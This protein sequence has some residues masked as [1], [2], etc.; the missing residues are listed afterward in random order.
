[1]LEYDLT[2]ADD[3]RRFEVATIPYQDMVGMDSSL[4]LLHEIGLGAVAARIHS[5]AGRLVEGIAA[6]S[7]LSLVTPREPSR[8]AGIVSFKVKDA[9]VVSARLNENDVSHS[10][11]GGGV[12]RLAPHIYNTDQQ[13][14]K[15]LALLNG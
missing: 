1:M 15:V 2:Y 13:I 8:R 9:G 11:R 3:A 6:I 12:I 14:D 5:L 7:T 4:E 10:I